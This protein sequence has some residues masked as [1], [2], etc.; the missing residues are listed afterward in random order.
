MKILCLSRPKLGATSHND[1]LE[2][3]R[4]DRGMATLE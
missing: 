1:I 3:M 2:L 4:S